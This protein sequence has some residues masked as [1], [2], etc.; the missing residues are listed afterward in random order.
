MATAAWK[1]LICMHISYNSNVLVSLRFT[2]SGVLLAEPPPSKTRHSARIIAGYRMG[3]MGMGGA[4][5]ITVPMRYSTWKHIRI[6]DST[7]SA[8]KLPEEQFNSTVLQ[9][10]LQ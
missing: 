5:D 6:T 2:F 9:L 1:V 8:Q 10:L 4:L 3:T 7:S